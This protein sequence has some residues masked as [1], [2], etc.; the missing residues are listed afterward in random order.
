MKINRKNEFTF[1]YFRFEPE[2]LRHIASI[3]DQFTFHSFRFEL[4]RLSLSQMRISSFTFHS[5]RFEPRHAEVLAEA[6]KHLHS[7]LLDLNRLVDG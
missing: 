3:Y 7:T 4:M 2:E 6:E 5:F 1:H